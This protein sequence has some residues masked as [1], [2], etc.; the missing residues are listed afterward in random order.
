MG[1]R[2]KKKLYY[3]YCLLCRDKYEKDSKLP[4]KHYCPICNEKYVAYRPCL[5]YFCDGKDR[6]S[7]NFSDRICDY[8]KYRS[9]MTMDQV[10]RNR[11]VFVIGRRV[12]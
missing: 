5:G 2:V 9:R 11:D 10:F 4:H 8:C 3:A 1:N 6:L 12:G 7:I